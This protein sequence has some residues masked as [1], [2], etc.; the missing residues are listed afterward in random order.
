MYM[1]H[2]GGLFAAVEERLEQFRG[3]CLEMTEV[4]V[5]PLS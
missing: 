5:T 1:K 2:F 3:A 4:F